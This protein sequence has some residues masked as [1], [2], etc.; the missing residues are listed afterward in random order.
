MTG[1]AGLA[2]WMVTLEDLPNPL[3]RVN[4]LVYPAHLNERTQPRDSAPDDQGVHLA[5]AFV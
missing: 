2:V 3:D 4:H 5:G 1:M